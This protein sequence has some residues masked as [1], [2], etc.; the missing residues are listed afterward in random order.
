[1]DVHDYEKEL[2][3]RSSMDDREFLDCMVQSLKSGTAHVQ[4][5]RR[6]IDESTELLRLSP[7]RSPPWNSGSI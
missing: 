1:M 2:A 7:G 4:S 6:L 5:S 3:E